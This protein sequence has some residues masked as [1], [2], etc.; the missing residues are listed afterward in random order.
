MIHI[1]SMHQQSSMIDEKT[2][3]N[4]TASSELAFSRKNNQINRFNFT[5][6]DKDQLSHEVRT[7]E[8]K[9]ESSENLESD[10]SSI[11]KM[12]K[13]VSHIY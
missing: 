6:I 9:H 1:Q 2:S 13:H 8:E 4:L 10:E 5:D 11:V 12:Q 3:Q 7:S